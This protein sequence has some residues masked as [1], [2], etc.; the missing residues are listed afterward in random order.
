MV[1]LEIVKRKKV[2]IG[3]LIV[4]LKKKNPRIR[5]MEAKNPANLDT[6]KLKIGVLF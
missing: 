1:N 5:I 2:E 3:M 4:V 6:I